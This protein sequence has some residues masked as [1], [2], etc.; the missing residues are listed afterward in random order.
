MAQLWNQFF[1]QF[2]SMAQLWTSF[3]NFS[4]GHSHEPVSL[5]GPVN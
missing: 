3:S 4:P 2:Q 1:N 5:H